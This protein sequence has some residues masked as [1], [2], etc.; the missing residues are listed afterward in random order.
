MELEVAKKL[1]KEYTAGH[2][3]MVVKSMI[4]ERYYNSENDILNMPKKEDSNKNP[5]H[6]ADNRIPHNF[7]GLLVNQ[8][9][10]YMFTSA[11]LF[12]VGNQLANSKITEVLG[13]KWAKV[14]KKL[15][16]NASNSGIAW[17][18]FWIDGE[19]QFQYG[20]VDSKQVIPVW[21]NDLEESLLAVLRV[22]AKIDE[23]TGD[24]YDI[25]EYW[26]DKE[27]QTFR[28]LA[29]ST[30]DEGLEAFCMFSTFLFDTSTTE[31][32]DLLAHEFEVVP[33][34]PFLNNDLQSG[35]LDNI[36]QLIDTYDKTYSGFVNDLE[37]IQEIIFVLSGYEGESLSGFL[38]NIKKYKSIKVNGGDGGAVS[39][40]TIDI[41]VEARDKLLTMTRKAIFE[42]GQGVDP[43]PQ[44]FG[45]ASGVALKYLYSLLELK[46]GLMETE[47]KLGFGTLIRVI[48]KY[49]NIECRQLVQT[50]TRT[51]IQNDLE[52]S[53]ICQNS[54]EVV[55]KRSIRKAHP[56]VEDISQEEKQI[57][58]EE[59]EEEEKMNDYE[60]AFKK[61]KGVD[62]D[63][64]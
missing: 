25:Y 22:Y 4:A 15:C 39:T 45:N 34:I 17:L 52:Q 13:D 51:A 38:N 12:D 23:S 63:E 2:S 3:D 59:Q 47:F 24:R 33:F 41:P 55:S 42:Q 16:V 6:N 7:H 10:A 21:E 14:C 64:E 31:E 1:I 18:H 40:L 62:V 35:D 57:K 26:T 44:N 48:C 36:K 46:A 30:V 9:A 49:F 27:C 58:A 43:D 60:G 5:L 8:K 28:K 37:D 61:S 56:L 50:W 11:P 32:S 54:L 53:Q 20:V 19:G 29:G